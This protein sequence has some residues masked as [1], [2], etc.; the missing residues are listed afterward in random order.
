MDLFGVSYPHYNKKYLYTHAESISFGHFIYVLKNFLNFKDKILSLQHHKD[1]FE[2]INNEDRKKHPYRHLDCLNNLQ[3]QAQNA[4]NLILYLRLTQNNFIISLVNS[5]NGDVLINVSSGLLKKKGVFNKK[6]N[7][8]TYYAVIQ[9]LSK[10]FKLLNLSYNLNIKIMSKFNIRQLNT[11]ILALE[12][13]GF[14][15]AQLHIC[16]PTAH[17]GCKIPKSKR[18]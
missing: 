9:K 2:T 6:K 5:K 3:S 10:K 8:R 4:N 16:V 18:F 15:I 17:N 13:C 7:F 11:I 12:S 14:Q 1:I